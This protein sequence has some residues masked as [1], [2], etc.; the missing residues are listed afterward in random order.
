[1]NYEWNMSYPTHI[2]KMP[3]VRDVRNLSNLFCY[4]AYMQWTD[5]RVLMKEM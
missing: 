3:A 5:L 4:T 2:M 1:M